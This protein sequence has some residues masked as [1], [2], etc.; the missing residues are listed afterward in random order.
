M[1][2]GTFRSC[3]QVFIPLLQELNLDW[4]YTGNGPQAFYTGN[5]PQAL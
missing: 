1:K 2:T 3:R 5:G 4:I